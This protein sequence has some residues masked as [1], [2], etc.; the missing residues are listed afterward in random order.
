MMVNII[1]PAILGG[2]NPLKS[3]IYFS[4]IG[5]RNLTSYLS[6]LMFWNKINSDYNLYLR[7]TRAFP[8]NPPF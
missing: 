3:Y 7:A 8:P 4:V 5:C 6:L 2:Y 1:V